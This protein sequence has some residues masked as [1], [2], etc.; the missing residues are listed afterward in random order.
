MTK[1]QNDICR[2]ISMI[3]SGRLPEEKIA[4]CFCSKEL[5]ALIDKFSSMFV[6]R[7][8]CKSICKDLNT[9]LF[10]I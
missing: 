7:A 8:S 5:S 3:A 1:L 4:D 10:Y 2:Y 6:D 9:W